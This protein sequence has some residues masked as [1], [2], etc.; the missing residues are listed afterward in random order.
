MSCNCKNAAKIVDANAPVKKSTEIRKRIFVG[1]LAVCVSIVATP[2][3]IGVLIYNIVFNGKYG[4][5][6]PNK[7][8]KRNK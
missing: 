1:T 8:L 3:I 7:L 4:I 5:T 6:F 2:I